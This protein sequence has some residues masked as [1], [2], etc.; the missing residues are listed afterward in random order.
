[1]LENVTKNQKKR[2]KMKKSEFEIVKEFTHILGLPNRT[3]GSLFIYN[4]KN[5]GQA[6]KPD[7]YYYYEGITFILDAKAEGKPFLNQLEDYMKLETNKNFIGFKYNGINFEC[8]IN[9]VLNEKE[10]IP[11]NKDYYKKTYFNLKINNELIV[12]KSAAKLAYLFRDSK[13]NKQMNIIFIGAA[14]LCMKYSEHIDLTST[15]SILTSLINGI[16]NIINDNPLSKKQKKEFI[17]TGLIEPTLQRA[18]TIDLINILQEI[19]TIYN[20]INISSID[21]KGHDIMNNFLRVFRKWNSIN[22]NEK[23]EVFTPDHIAQLMYEIIEC[24]K[25]NIIL[26][27]T[28]GSGTF[29]T[30]AL[31]NMLSETDDPLI[32]KNIQE[33]N[34]I[35]IEIDTFNS[36]LTGIN[37]LLHGD[38]SS[39]IFL[40][41][42]FRK[43]P[44]LKNCYDRVLMNPPFSLKEKEL[45]FVEKTI[46]NLKEEGKLATILPKSCLKGKDKTELSYLESIFKKSKLSIVISLPNDLFQPN[47]AV[48]TCIAVFEKNKKGHNGKTLFINCSDDGF[49]FK[50]GTRERTNKWEN[51][52]ENILK[53]VKD[54][55][56]TEFLAIEKEV[57]YNDELLFEAYSSN[58]SHEIKKETFERYMKEYIS[59]KILC[60]KNLKEKELIINIEDP[61]VFDKIKISDI[62]IYIDKGKEKKSIDRKL[63][64]KYNSNGIPLI[65]AKKDNNGIGGLILNPKK[66]FSNKFCIIA[67]GDGGGGKT[68]YNNFQFA[69]TSFVLICDLI[70]KYRNIDEYSKFYLSVVISERLY[71]TIG[72][73]R[74]I[75]KIPDLEITLPKTKNGDLDF[76]YMSNFIKSLQYS[77][78]F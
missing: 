24:S 30:N 47:A 42:C 13:I 43:I 5:K 20:F 16:E 46:D 76:N 32:Q 70:E 31:A 15:S 72:H 7:G 67:G 37:M 50:N 35:G 59:S 55:V 66:I 44:Q 62:L 19:S 25:E 60:G 38:G 39:N 57:K 34:L 3:D 54:K 18:K 71:K 61:Y 26:D 36:T 4:S 63:E 6:K 23:G 40:D 28:C 74:T 1:M 10:T 51:I 52:Q 64:D 21:R 2:E 75:N 8:Y 65:I 29:L 77:K 27:P 11:Q 49:E 78:W 48:S 58:R 56:Y 45:K 53:S 12:E 73:G 9:G 68:Y 22:A 14:M 69:A 41:D 33:N 17:K